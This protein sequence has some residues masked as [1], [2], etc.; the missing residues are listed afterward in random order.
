MLLE[1]IMG[2]A[3]KV[4]LLRLFFEYPNR[5]FTTEEVFENT[6]LGV[7]Y[8]L[9]CLKLLL[10]SETIQMKKSGKQKKYSL[11]KENIFYQ[12]FYEIFKKERTSLPN[13]SFI[14]RGVIADVLEKLGEE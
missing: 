9:K 7:G 14:H 4:K 10:A 11:N 6:N 1:N 2:S 12:N 5:V 13:I 3:T 8:G